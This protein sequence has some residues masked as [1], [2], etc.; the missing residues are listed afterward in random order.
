MSQNGS[1]AAPLQ[2]SSGRRAGGAP[3]D[4]FALTRINWDRYR[5]GPDALPH[6]RIAPRAAPTPLTAAERIAVDAAERLERVEV[7]AVQ[8]ECRTR[9]STKGVLFDLRLEYVGDRLDPIPWLSLLVSGGLMLEKLSAAAVPP[10][11]VLLP[12]WTFPFSSPEKAKEAP[13]VLVWRAKRRPID[14]GRIAADLLLTTRGVSPAR[15]RVSSS[16]CPPLVARQRQDLLSFKRVLQGQ[17]RHRRH[18]RILDHCV[19]CGQPLRD[20]KSARLGIGPE[21]IKSYSAE[22]RW[23]A[24]NRTRDTRLSAKPPSWWGTAVTDHWGLSIDRDRTRA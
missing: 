9:G 6:R 18:L 13:C 22:K 19:K 15:V 16:E 23:V 1:G 7:D 20:P 8:L 2:P 11:S 4:P 3:L 14:C 21:C 17:T 12:P 5:D 10:D 24:E